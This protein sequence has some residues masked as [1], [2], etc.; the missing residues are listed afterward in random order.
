[1]S[2]ELNNSVEPSTDDIRQG[3]A[4]L[5][6]VEIGASEAPSSKKG[7]VAGIIAGVLVL[8]AAIVC[9]IVFVIKKPADDKSTISI[10]TTNSAEETVSSETLTS[11][12]TP[13]EPDASET[14][15]APDFSAGLTVDGFVQDAD[16][17]GVKDLDVASVKVP[18]GAI[19]YLEDKAVAEIISAAEQYASFV[20]DSSLTVEN[21]NTINLNYAGYMD[22]VQFQGG[23][24]DNQTLV[25]G[26]GSFIDTFEEQLIGAHPGDDVTVN[27]SFPDPYPNNPDFSGKPAVFECHVNSILRTPEVN[28]EFVQTYFSDIA[29]SYEGL[30][31]FVMDQ[32][33][34]SNLQSYLA[35]YISENCEVTTLSDSYI[36]HIEELY[37]YT[38]RQS[39]DQYKT[40]MA[41]YGQDVSAMTF[42]DYTGM[43]DEAYEALISENARKQA[44]LDLT[45]ESIFKNAGLSVD[46]ETY[47]QI[48]EY[49]GGEAQA[50]QAYGE[51]YVKQTAIKYA[52]INYLE[53]IVEITDL[54]EE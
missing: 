51:P 43:T 25:I 16:L 22:G 29:D 2:D 32:G 15:E 44:A 53:G 39:F 10:S 19:A 28:D 35:G 20:D 49:Y 38:D 52:V 11:E 33:R 9:V 8:A 54:P 27:V 40:Y 18:Y 7:L 47:S 5:N 45:Y 12:E 1:M 48:L 46:D 41:Y 21:G 13:S 36:K 4:T 50:V 26:S 34:K 23:T 30:K 42:S 3:E 17:S 6:G 14:V 31:A 37:R 24:A